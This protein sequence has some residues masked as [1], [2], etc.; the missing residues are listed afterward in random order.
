MRGLLSILLVA[1]ACTAPNASEMF[2]QID[3][4]L[5]DGAIDTNDAFVS[6]I[7]GATDSLAIALPIGTDTTLTDSIIDA[8][9]R[10]V[11]VEVV[12]DYDARAEEG[13]AALIDAGVPHK[14]ADDGLGYFEFSFNADVSWSSEQTIMSSAF[15]VADQQSF[16]SSTTAG[17]LQAGPRVLVSGIGENLVEDLLSEHNQLFGDAD[18]VA[19]TAFDAPAKSIVDNRWSY[20]MSSGPQLELWFGPQERVTKRIIDA[21][22]GAKSSVWVMTD[23]FANEGL[24]R[25]L[26][27]K[28]SQDFDI[29]VITGPNLGNS[30]SAL[31]R[32]FQTKTDDVWKREVASGRVPTLVFVDVEPAR[33]GRYYPAQVFIVSHD[34]YSS[35][36]FFKTTEVVTSQLI[37]G[38]LWVVNDPTHMSEELTDLVGLW[39][40]TVDAV[41]GQ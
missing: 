4:E 36:R 11:A 25:A 30:S 10:G 18:A 26:Q 29:R 37:D 1:S 20:W 9:E 22:Y 33:D 40:D 17:G 19:V 32:D 16:I 38:T 14:L 24:R 28:A 2:N 7:D 21:V 15:V 23:D 13:F 39:N 12:L 35:A 34:L 8:H 31:M 5:V 3:L 6:V 27:T 41:G